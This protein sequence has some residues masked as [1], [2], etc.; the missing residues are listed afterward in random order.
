MTSI[1]YTFSKEE[2]KKVIESSYTIKE[3]IN[4]LGLRD[5]GNNRKTFFRYVTKILLEKE[6]ED[7]RERSKQ[8]GIK[9]RVSTRTIPDD[10]VF[11]KNSSLAR[12]HL[13][14]RILSRNLFPYRCKH[15]GNEGK[16]NN[17]GLVLQLE[18]INGVANDNRLDNLCFL[19]PNCHSQTKTFAGRQ[20]RKKPTKEERQKIRDIAFSIKKQEFLKK[21]SL[22]LQDVDK[23]KYGSLKKIA[24]Y[25]GVSHTHMRRL[26]KKY[27]D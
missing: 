22:C 12:R 21:L 2:I 3:A 23:D 10:K 19:C 8:E 14:R 6:L 25:F 1:I 26:L 4:K 9:K 17:K 16:W 5:V 7:L 13:I 15:C 11:C 27:S 24:D 20:L 18:H